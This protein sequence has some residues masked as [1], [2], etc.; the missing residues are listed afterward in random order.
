MRILSASLLIALVPQGVA[1]GQRGSEPTLVLRLS[2]GM[3]VTSPTLWS[4]PRQPVIV[5]GTER[6]ATPLFD[7]LSLA[8]DFTTGL[9][10]GLHAVY[11]P[12]PWAGVSAAVQYLGLTLHDACGGVYFDPT[13][14]TPNREMCSAIQG[15]QRSLGAVQL[16]AGG[17]LR[18]LPRA[19]VSPY[20][21]AAVGLVAY[22]A[23]TVYLE[24]PRATGIQVIIDDPQPRHASP[25]LTWGM[26]ITSA[27]SPGYGM[28]LEAREVTAAFDHVT[29]PADRLA[30]APASS[31]YTT[32]IVFSLG[33]DIV[34]DAKRGRRY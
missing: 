27:L 11:F 31:R 17:V 34:L 25:T 9:A 26:G 32:H 24:G 12:K 23:S 14:G 30:R 21:R 6:S 5:P 10:F 13:L 20:L 8:R 3:L 18:P 16:E 2:A 4:D 28:H 15:A 22:S 7:T 19:A 33:L 29:G 1:L